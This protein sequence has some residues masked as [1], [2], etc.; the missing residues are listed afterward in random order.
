MRL[1]GVGPVLAN[2][3]VSARESD[4]PFASV[5]DL[6]RVSGVGPTRIE[7]FRPLVTISP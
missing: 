6:R 7:R 4:G 2:R 3:I 1:P 5:D